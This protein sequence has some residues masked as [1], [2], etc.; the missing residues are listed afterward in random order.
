MTHQEYH[1]VK[2]EYHG[3]QLA[4]LIK[5]RKNHRKAEYHAQ[6]VEYHLS[7]G[8]ENVFNYKRRNPC[9]TN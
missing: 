8:A 9:V 7:R 4:H 2:Y 3:R 6:K 1:Q 5:L